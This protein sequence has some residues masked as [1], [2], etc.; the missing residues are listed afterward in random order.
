VNADGTLGAKSEFATFRLPIDPKGEFK[1]KTPPPYRQES[2]GDGMS[3]DARGIVYITSALGVQ[4]FGADG[5]LIG[6]L[7]KMSAGKPLTSVLAVPA[8][9]PTRVYLYATHGDTMF[10]RVLAAK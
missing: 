4:I 1:M 3:V 5:R 2:G 10:R 7:P 9:D 8:A 6:V